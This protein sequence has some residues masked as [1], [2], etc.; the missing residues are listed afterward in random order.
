MDRRERLRKLALETIDLAKVS[1]QARTTTVAKTKISRIYR[2]H[3]SS[4]TISA[5]WNVVSVSH[6]TQMRARI[7]R[8]RKVRS[9]RQILQDVRLVT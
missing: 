4:A 8:I 7:L 5:H 6:F 3:T 1:P 2:T 9:T